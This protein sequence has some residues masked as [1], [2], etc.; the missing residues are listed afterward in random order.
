MF[1]YLFGLPGAGKN[2]VGRIL[3]ESYGLSF[4][5]GDAYLTEE[6]R[7]AVRNHQP[8]TEPMRDRYYSHLIAV[9]GDLRLHNNPLAVGQATFKE[10]H[11]RQILDAYPDT[12]FILVEAA[13]PVR[14]ARLKRRQDA[15]TEDYARRIESFFEPPTHPHYVISNNRGRRNVEAQLDELLAELN[16]QVSP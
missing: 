1:L 15:V 12:N 6:L 7:V 10:R 11:R 9:I 8:F 2:Y 4:Y 14:M 16:S 13:E 3:A 5:D